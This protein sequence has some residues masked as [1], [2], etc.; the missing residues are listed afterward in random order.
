MLSLAAFPA[1]GEISL[2]LPIDCTLGKTCH[3]QHHV[4][5]DLGPK[6]ADFRCGSLSYD[7]H[8]GVD[9]ALPTLA[10]MREGVNVLAAAPGRVTGIRDGMADV[11]F[12]QATA[13]ETQGRE[14]GNGVVVRH[15]NGF[16]TQYCHLMKGSVRAQ[17]GD[18]VERG[19]ILGLVGLSGR[20]QFP[21]LHLAVRRNGKVIDPF[22][23][24]VAD[25]CTTTGATLWKHDLPYAPG[26]L[27]DIGFANA[28]P[29]YDAVRNG[30]VTANNTSSDAPALVVFGFAF[31]GQTGDDIQLRITGP[32]GVVSQQTQT[33]D[34]SQARFFRAVGR[35]QPQGGWPKGEYV[36]TVTLFRDQTAY[37]IR[38]TVLVIK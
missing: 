27:L 21:H 36:G 33:L 1:A 4:D 29:N 10:Q 20:T 24:G 9:F 32:Q 14:C 34:R 5:R 16:E 3:I 22:D 12:T 23:P 2:S 31:G 25:D 8:K 6:V 26:G 38:T 15:Y 28:V 37:D 19:T 13:G 7:G 11:E 35:R 18:I 30:T 17:K